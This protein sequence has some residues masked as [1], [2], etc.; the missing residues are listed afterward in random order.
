MDVIYCGGR[1]KLLLHPSHVLTFGGFSSF[2]T[3]LYCAI[4]C[5][6]YVLSIVFSLGDVRFR[7]AEVL[8]KQG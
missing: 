2:V 1:L 3:V 6:Q 8:E 7:F 5:Y 4:L